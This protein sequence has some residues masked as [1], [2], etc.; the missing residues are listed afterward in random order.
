MKMNFTIQGKPVKVEENTLDRAIRWLAPAYGLKRFRA[1]TYAAIAGGYNG[2]RR[3]RN[4]TKQWVP[5]GN[6][7]DTDIIADLPDLRGRSRDL[8]RNNAVAASA[9]N[10]KVVN[11]VGAGLQLHANID[12]ALLN[13]TEDEAD[14]WEANA[15]RWFRLWANNPN[16]CDL[17]R[18][19]TF[20]EKQNLVYRQ[21]LENGDVFVNKPY[22]ERPGCYFGLKLQEVEADRICNKDLGPDTETLSAGI[23]FSLETGEPTWYHVA[24][25]HP[26]SLKI[27]R[28]EWDRLPVFNREGRRNIY[29]LY[30]MLRPGQHRGVPHLAPVIE[31]LKQIGNLTDNELQASVLQSVFTA[32]I[33]TEGGDGELE[34]T[35]SDNNTKNST[36]DSIILGSG[37]I[38]GLQPGQDVEFANPTRPNNAFEPFFGAVI[39]QLGAAIGIPREVL[40]KRFTASYSAA[41]AALQDA[42]KFFLTSRAWLVTRYCQPVY[43]DWMDEAVA[44]DMLQAPGYFDNPLI[45]RAYQGAIWI[46]PAKGMIR[47][48]VEVDAALKRADGGI[49]TLE[50]ESASIMGLDWEGMHP[51]RVKEVRR[52]VRDGLQQDPSKPKNAVLPAPKSQEPDPKQDKKEDETE[53]K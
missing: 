16:E 12:A 8:N 32:F 6:D 23:E 31:A 22:L 43:C 13:M 52:R 25:F 51:Q 19:L 35:P 40:M 48:D 29:H 20:G 30:E 17:A 1:R 21:T 5:R 41:M 46:G 45:R 11:V 26:G 36:E 9:T 42:W 10:T 50:Y 38:L 34:L 47:E 39:E 24:K 4:A 53:E 18:T 28:R 49:S 7:P 14:A 37:N 33:K 27:V 3:D 15:Q 2:G 44:R